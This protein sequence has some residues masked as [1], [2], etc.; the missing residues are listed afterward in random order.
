LSV[1]AS[2]VRTLSLGALS[3]VTVGCNN[4]D[5]PNVDTGNNVS[6]ADGDGFSDADDCD[7]QN[8]TIYPDAVEVCDG[9][10]NDCDGEIDEDATEA[11]TWY[12]DGDGDGFGTTDGAIV[13]C[14][15]P[16]GYAN[17]SGDC[18][19]ADPLISPLG[20]EVCDELDNDCD[21]EIDEDAM[22]AESLW[23]DADGDGYGDPDSPVD[24][25][26]DDGLV[27]DDTD[28]DDA[29]PDVNPGAIDDWYDDVDSDC[30]GE[31]NPDVCDED[32]PGGE[33]GAAD[34]TC[35]YTPAAPTSWSVQVE[36]TTDPASGWVWSI[37]NSYTRVM[38]TPVVGQLTDDN[39]D[40]F[41]DDT[42]IPDIV[43]NTFQNGNYSSA[44]ILRVVSG[45]GSGEHF[46]VAS[47]TDG[48]S[49]Y[50]P[51]G[52][53]GVALGDIDGDGSPEI[54]TVASNERVMVLEATGALKFIAS[55]VTT[56]R[57]TYPTIADMDGDGLAEIIAGRHIWDSTGNLLASS[58]VSG[59]RTA[60]AADLDGDGQQE[61][62]GGTQV[63]NLDGSYAWQNTTLAAGAPAV[64]DWDGDG[65]GDVLNLAA[66]S[67]TVFDESGNILVSQSLGSGFSGSPCVGDLDGDGSPEVAMSSATEVVAYDT[68]GTL[69][70]TMPNNDT[71][72]NGTPCTAWDF[73]GDGD[74]E[75]LIADHEE[76]RIHDGGSGAVLLVE[77][78]HASGTIREQPVPVDV[79]R[80]GNTEVVLASND[81]AYNGWDGVTVLGEANDEWTSTRTTWNQG[82]FWSGNIND[83]MS[84]PTAPD[85]PWDLDNSFRSQVSPTAEP[86]ATQDYEVEILGVCEDC[87]SD[88]VEVWVS[89]VNS[90][91]IFGP[92]GIDVALY[93]DDGGSLTLLDVLPS[94]AT[95]DAGERLAP[96]TFVISVADIGADGLV[97]SADD[98]GTGAGAH[99]ECEEANNTAAWNET[100]CE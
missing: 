26:P 48:T 72:S 31:S 55:G 7:D 47:V 53:A 34:L 40:G 60:F 100:V 73:D 75:V 63:M 95:I 61:H 99:N 14:D 91:G 76:F 30:D 59:G 97:A 21:G 42:D 69:L 77:T 43:F 17:Q 50:Y 37:G 80:D 19:D 11:G 9:L 82:P 90:G 27:D 51:A 58:D 68:D 36:W 41:I 44:G 74:F 49:T 70:W 15:P 56:S 84:V 52:A 94:T 3:L 25:C 57:Y 8:N 24:A 45:D 28:C 88:Q 81:Y 64:M 71:S 89:L 79:D 12:P 20:C 83:D 67:F 23:V 93:A 98:D 38:A 5:K 87:P 1:L 46:S 39:G 86:L 65:D 54:V 22:D 6:D 2:S 62:I 29:D 66:G 78:G 96:M 33:L 92:A 35:T 85:M 10:D 32:P 4:S 13:S 18:D 16:E